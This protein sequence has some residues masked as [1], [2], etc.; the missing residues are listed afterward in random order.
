MEEKEEKEEKSIKKHQKITKNEEK[1]AK[2]DE[3]GAHLDPKGAEMDG[4]SARA[5][6]KCARADQQGAI[7]DPNGAKTDEKSAKTDGKGARVDHK[8]A[9]SDPKCAIADPKCALPDPSGSKTDEKGANPDPSGSKTDGN[10]ALPDLKCARADPNDAI[11]DQQSAKTD[12]KGTHLDQKGASNEAFFIVPSRVFDMSLSP[13]EFSVLCYLIMRSDNENHTCFPSEKSIA[14]ACGM[15]LA[16]VGRTVKLLQT[17]ELINIKKQFAA[18][19]NGTNRQTSNLYTVLL[20]ES[21]LHNHTEHPPSS[22][23]VAPLI[24]QS[25]EIN[26]TKPNITKSNITIP[27]ELSMSEAQEVEKERFSFSELKRECFE[28]LKNERGIDEELIALLDRSLEHLWFKNEAEYEGRKYSQNELRAM[29]CTKVTPDALAYSAQS[30][31]AAGTGVR[32][33]VPYLAKCLLGTLVKGALHLKQGQ[34][35]NGDPFANVIK[36]PENFNPS[37]SSFDLDDFF[38]AALND[39]Y[40]FQS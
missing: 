7:S 11:S 6:S 33:P 25:R 10:G 3:K 21:T 37:A 34:N 26:K 23:R 19:K 31:R 22:E 8:C 40:G 30:L 27:T 17:K 1:N 14:S 12:G 32:S 24:T 20:S 35:D 39:T 15:G 18:T 13:Y 38:A 29:L 9:I 16:T 5:D 4:K 2:N 36:P 28:I